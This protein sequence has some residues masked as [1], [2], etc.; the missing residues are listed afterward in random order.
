MQCTEVHR[1][2]QKKT[3]P[4]EFKSIEYPNPIQ[5]TTMGHAVESWSHRSWS[6]L[7]T[8]THHGRHHEM[9][10]FQTPWLMGRLREILHETKPFQG[11]DPL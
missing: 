4:P 5:G 2:A 11:N 7:P 9:E 6:W 8:S 10:Q 1:N 3:P